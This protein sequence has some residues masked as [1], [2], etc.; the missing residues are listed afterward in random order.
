[1]RAE[2]DDMPNYLKGRKKKGPWGMLLAIGAVSSVAWGLAMT[3]GKPV[4]IDLAK[5]KE[6]IHFGGKP[7]FEQPRP[8][9]PEQVTAAPE[10][11]YTPKTKQQYEPER[12]AVRTA[13]TIPA[14]EVPQQKQTVFHD[15]NYVPKGAANVTTLQ[16]QQENTPVE[17][18]KSGTR[19]TII[20]DEPRLRDHCARAF[21]AGSIEL[22]DC[23]RRADY[24][25]RNSSY[26]GN[27]N[28]Y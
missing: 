14:V 17:K 24:M 12:V 3:Y 23:R 6:G 1:M 11:S 26:S 2:R 19:I 22:R 5:I 16:S 27:R 25:E 4:V 21:K 13:P 7:V 10:V 15:R 20:G 8:A 9:I 18:A 28:P